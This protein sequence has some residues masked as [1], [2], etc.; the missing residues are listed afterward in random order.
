VE[1][2]ASAWTSTTFSG[3]TPN[4]SITSAITDAAVLHGVVHRDAVGHELHQVLVGGNDGR[5]GAPLAG[6]AY[7]GR[8]QIIGLEA[9]LLEAGQVERAHRLADQRKLRDQIVRRRR[10]V[11]LVVGIELVAESD[12]GFVEDDGEVGRPVVRRH[13]AQQLPQHIAEAKHGVDLQPIGFAVQR[14]QRVIGAKNIGGTVDQ[15]DVVAFRRG[16]DG[17][18]FGEGLFGGFR[19]GRNLRIFAT[20]DSLRG[21]FF[22]VTHPSYMSSRATTAWSATPTMTCRFPAVSGFL[23][24]VKCFKTRSQNSIGR[25]NHYKVVSCGLP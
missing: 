22:G 23:S 15:K 8:D 6:L 11:R 13:I 25:A 5:N 9:D 21:A 4:F 24:A 7:I 19:H 20:I 2:P 3:G 16:F 12:F 17:N 10:A 18:G 1:S 14:R